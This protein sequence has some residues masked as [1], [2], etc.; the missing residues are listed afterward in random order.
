MDKARETGEELGSVQL[1][2]RWSSEGCWYP[3]S[4]TL[5]GEMSMAGRSSLENAI[6]AELGIPAER[7]YWSEN[8]S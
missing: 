8:G 3:E 1:Q 6:E 7:Q 2:M 4:V 5:T